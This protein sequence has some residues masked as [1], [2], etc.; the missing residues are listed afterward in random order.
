M[1]QNT[2]RNVEQKIQTTPN[3]E[4]ERDNN[5][6]QALK[7]NNKA[8]PFSKL[9]KAL[10][11]GIGL[12]SLL[13]MLLLVNLRT[14]NAQQQRQIQDEA[15]K[16]QAVVAK[17]TTLRQEISELNSSSRLLQ[18]ANEHNLTLRSDNIRNISK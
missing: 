14:S 11:I 8:V 13:M 10:V 3:I 1:L 15:T 7:V 2:A 12:I 5:V 18:I 4:N 17:N 9:E 16:T 6:H